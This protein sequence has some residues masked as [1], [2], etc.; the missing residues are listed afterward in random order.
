MA[1]PYPAPPRPA[2]PLCIIGDLHGMAGLLEAMLARIA[3]QPDAERARVVLVGDLIDRGPESAAVLHRVRELC[4]AEPQ[5]FICLLGNHERMLLNF[6]QNPTGKPRKWLNAG[7]M[8]TL[9]SF[10][11][12]GRF[13]PAAGL[14][15]AAIAQAL[16][17]ALPAG[18]EDWLRALPL[19]WQGDGVGVV[20][21]SADP[22]CPLPA[23]GEK[24]LL[25][26]QHRPG[27]PRPDGLWI[28][29][30]HVIGKTAWIEAGEISVDT[31]AYRSGCLSA[32]W[33]DRQGCE[34]LQV[35]L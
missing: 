28:A 13:D 18:M 30:G 7:G 4:S 29:H 3:R 35:S 19:F 22:S 15:L 9:A 5:R 8:E 12:S 23:Q 31:G 1:P 11:L 32:A 17:A 6:L 24:D 27:L 21:A 10:G 14:P 16:R 20:H 25:W 26:G 2:L 33:L 34:I